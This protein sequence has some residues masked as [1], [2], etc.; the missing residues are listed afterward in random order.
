MGLEPLLVTGLAMEKS[1]EKV[2]SIL[3][4][5]LYAGTWLPDYSS[6][7]S[8]DM[9]KI[10]LFS[11]IIRTSRHTQCPAVLV[12]RRAAIPVD[13]FRP[14]P[15]PRRVHEVSDWG[16]RRRRVSGDLP[17]AVCD[18]VGADGARGGGVTAIAG[19]Q[20]LG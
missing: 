5:S 4:V 20:P 13:A 8:P 2:Q 17:V 1:L 3:T 9:E 14:A 12:D 19:T 11:C 18:G 6:S 7:E 10:K 16:S 15:S